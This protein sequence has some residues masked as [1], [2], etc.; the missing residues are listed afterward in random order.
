MRCLRRGRNTM[1]LSKLIP[2]LAVGVLIFTGCEGSKYP[3]SDPADSSIDERMLGS[4][5]YQAEESE[6]DSFVNIFAF[7]DTQYY[8]ESW[9][10]GDED[11]M[12]RMNVFTT[13]IDGI[14]FANLRCINCE[15]EDED[16][17][18]LFLKYELISDDHLKVQ[19]IDDDEYDE[20][21][22]LE[23]VDAVNYFVRK[24]MHERTFFEEDAGVYERMDEE[25]RRGG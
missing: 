19:L 21:E 8:V 16:K 6:D 7:N 14:L 23:S 10:E 3:L 9:E 22:E 25:P 4:W 20:I 18:Y 12:L 24:K 1:R 17:P 15:D 13:D 11:E 5:Q 2:L